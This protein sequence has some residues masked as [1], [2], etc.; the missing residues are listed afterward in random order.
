MQFRHLHELHQAA[1]DAVVE[2]DV[3][4][5]RADE[6]DAGEKRHGIGHEAAARLALELRLKALAEMPGRSLRDGG[7]EMRER[8]GPAHGI[9]GREA[10]ADIE[11]ADMHAG[12]ARNAGS[13]LDV[14]CVN[15][16]IA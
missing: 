4:A 2:E 13:R 9:A 5:I 14:A 12:R 3:V 1:V 15:G 16:R 8:R 7:K 11:L 10:A 6:L